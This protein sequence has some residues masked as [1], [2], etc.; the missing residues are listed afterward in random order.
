MA[1]IQVIGWL[2][3]RLVPVVEWQQQLAV[4]MKKI[5]LTIHY[6]PNQAPIKS[7]KDCL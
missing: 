5:L 4:S 3:E 1:I 7:R 2:S 6:P